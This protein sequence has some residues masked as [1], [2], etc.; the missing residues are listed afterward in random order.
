VSATPGRALVANLDIFMA[1]EFDPRSH[2]VR[3]WAWSDGEPA[4][5][6]LA[7]LGRDAAAAL[8]TVPGGPEIADA[9][10]GGKH[11]LPAHGRG[12]AIGAL[13]WLA[14]ELRR[15]DRVLVG[16]PPPGR[17]RLLW[18]ALVGLT[19]LTRRPLFFYSETWL[20]PAGRDNALQRRLDRVLA[21][22]ATTILV[23]GRLQQGHYERLG[24][25]AK[26]RRIGS[27]YAPVPGATVP[28]TPPSTPELLFVGRTMPLKG[29]DRLLDLVDRLDAEGRRVRLVALLHDPGNQFV[30]RDAGYASR[31]EERLRARDP[32]LTEVHVERVDVGAF[33]ARASALVVPNRIIRH[34]KV[35]GESWGR[36]VPEAL[37]AGLPVVSTDA[38][39]SAVEY[40]VAGENGTVVPWEDES[41]LAAAVRHW[42]WP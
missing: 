18:A 5:A 2:D 30:G 29:L 24:R 4:Q 10:V 7:R 15:A 32:E 20:S 6:V 8:A 39:P 13:R 28:R 19:V 11:V 38:V 21:A 36:I 12:V 40:V 16:M 23:P 41:A 34:D 25:G 33:Y 1:A 3:S 26:V 31:C 9:Y 37:A 17:D 35:P 42:L 14:G 27:P 22:L